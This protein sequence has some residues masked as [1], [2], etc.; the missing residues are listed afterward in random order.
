MILRHF[1]SLHNVDGLVVG[2]FCRHEATKAETKLWLLFPGT[3]AA[4]KMHLSSAPD[5]WL[6]SVRRRILLNVDVEPGI[7]IIIISIT[8]QQKTEWGTA[9]I[10]LWGY[11]HLL[12][13][14]H[15]N[16]NKICMYW[17]VK[18]VGIHFRY[19]IQKSLNIKWYQNGIQNIVTYNNNMESRRFIIV[20]FRIHVDD[21]DTT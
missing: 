1:N 18:V 3:D 13:T 16:R 4:I 20:Q 19:E 12:Q 14:T 7:Q 2:G 5:N 6:S 17:G 15:L 9:S 8:P 11:K 10:N 21:L